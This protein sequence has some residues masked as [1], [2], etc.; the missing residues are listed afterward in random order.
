MMSTT[1]LLKTIQ[2]ECSW[3]L[4]QGLFKQVCSREQ[5]ADIMTKPLPR[6]QF[7]H[8]QQKLCGWWTCYDPIWKRKEKR[9]ILHIIHDLTRMRK[10]ERECEEMAWHELWAWPI[11]ACELQQ[12]HDRVN[13]YNG[14]WSKVFL[15][16]SLNCPRS[17]LW[18]NLAASSLQFLRMLQGGYCT[19]SWM[20]SWSASPLKGHSAVI[21]LDLRSL[22]TLPRTKEKDIT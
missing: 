10:S 19:S 5:E 11:S 3:I 1:S 12:A 9:K 6:P 8:L 2:K 15:L 4:S 13:G 18:F 20:W 7:Q 17:F 22:S 14:N 16:T 21:S